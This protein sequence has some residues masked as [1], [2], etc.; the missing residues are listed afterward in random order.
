MD[1]FDILTPA[2]TDGR[3]SALALRR[4]RAVVAPD[5]LQRVVQDRAMSSGCSPHILGPNCQPRDEQGRFVA[6]W[7]LALRSST[8]S[9]TS[10]KS[11]DSRTA[12][13]A[14]GRALTWQRAL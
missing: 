14:D 12:L 1:A 9:S 2:K 11:T 3:L 5:G 7:V 6:Y 10:R 4:L 8:T 13:T